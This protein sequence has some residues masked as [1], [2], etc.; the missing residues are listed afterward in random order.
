MLSCLR[1]AS[2]ESVRNRRLRATLS[3]K[4]CVPQQPPN[5][6]LPSRSADGPFTDLFNGILQ[7]LVE[8]LIALR[9]H[10]FFLFRALVSS[11]QGHYL[12]MRSHERM[13]VKLDVQMIEDRR[14]AYGHRATDI[15]DRNKGSDRT[16][17]YKTVI[18]H[19][20]PRW[21]L[22]SPPPRLYILSNYATFAIFIS[23]GLL[24]IRSFGQG[25]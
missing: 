1:A 21:E 22:V 23:W 14:A 16:K 25:S 17:C 2:S 13:S 24:A 4:H 18:A 12:D 6:N 19:M 11:E 7:D 15:D 9:P 3:G 20:H 5:V 8:V 10:V